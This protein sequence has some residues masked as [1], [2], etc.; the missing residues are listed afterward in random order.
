LK[1]QVFLFLVA[2]LIISACKKDE[3]P[4]PKRDSG[5]L[6]TATV[7]L[8]ATYKW[9]VYYDI[10]TNSVVG[11]NL[12]T[13]WDLA[14]ETT[15][16]GYHIFLN[17]SKVMFAFNTGSTGFYEVNDTIGY[18]AN[19]KLDA[20]SGNLD[21]TA[22]GNW[23]GL[24]HVYIIDRG[25]DEFG[26]HLGFRKIQFLSVDELK[27]TIRFAELNN[28]DEV[29][30]NVTKDANYNFSFLSFST[31]NTL[32]V[33]PPKETWD[34]VFTQYTHVFYNPFHPYLVVGCLLNS[35]NTSA[36]LINEKTFEEITF[37]DVTS[38]NLSINRNAIGYDWKTFTGITFVT[39]PEMNYIIKDSE[40]IYYK[41]H[42]I[43]FYNQFGTKGNP[44]WE[45]Q[46]L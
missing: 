9:Q 17:S 45:H 40:G 21:S 5:D 4:V 18:A 46:E 15:S 20:T 41:L 25:Y 43:D 35:Y 10:K 24:N 29:N 38:Y 36:I 44:T 26:T 23:Q 12:K 39:D 16:D 34:L 14:F 22:I 37:D 32:N 30:I 27:Y 19:S 2:L 31:S 3:L 11:Q 42:F 8:D 7:N 33:E 6:I 13:V 28:D 1:T